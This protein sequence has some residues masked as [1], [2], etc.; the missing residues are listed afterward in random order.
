MG[1]RGEIVRFSCNA[2]GCARMKYVEITR[3][4]VSV[5][6]LCFGT[7]TLGRLQLKTPVD[8]G[9]TVIA[10][11]LQKGVN[12][13]DTAQ[14]YATYPHVAEALRLHKGPRPVLASKSHARTSD[15]MAKAVYEALDAMGV[16]K[17]DFFDL[18]MVRG[19]EDLAEREPVV[20]RLVKL[21]EQG[22]IRA[23]GATMHTIEGFRAAMEHDEIELL[24][25]I[26][27]EKGLGLLDGGIEDLIPHL[28][29]AKRRGRWL[30]AMKP[31][32]GGHLHADVERA[33]AWLRGQ[34][35]VDVVAMGMQNAAEV[36]MNV[37]L[38]NDEPLTQAMRDAARRQRKRIIIYDTCKGCGSCEKHCPQEAIKVV[39]GKARVTA[40]KC[41]LCG[42]CAED[43][44][45][46]AIRVI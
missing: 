38:F 34:A 12:F 46:F 13:I 17:V 8:E 44:P 27:N 40:D 37:A 20:Q 15:D 39:E 23:I 14:A 41:I 35:L 32:G 10:T 24:M 31:L 19:K 1:V 4:K 5:S 21:R 2:E 42:Y 29:E 22:V 9:A 16:T 18:H 36:A 3:A 26:V 25:P 11:A 43:C 33:I 45:A 30:Y 28:R 7:L 6:E